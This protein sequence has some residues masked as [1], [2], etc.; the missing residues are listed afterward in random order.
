MMTAQLEAVEGCH[1]TAAGL[2]SLS[3]LS[4][5]LLLMV[6]AGEC[7]CQPAGAQQTAASAAA[8]TGPLSAEQVVKNMVSMNLDRFKALHGYHVTETY[9]LEYQGFLGTRSA[10]MA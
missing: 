3:P 8:V 4:I 9:R 1:S 2:L 10:N 7:Q 6:F 5:L